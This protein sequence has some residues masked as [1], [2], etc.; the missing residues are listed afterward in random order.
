MSLILK[1]HVS[2]NVNMQDEIWNSECDI[3][4]ESISRLSSIY[5]YCFKGENE[6]KLKL[7]YNYLQWSM[8][9]YTVILKC[10][11]WANGVPVMTAHMYPLIEALII[12]V[13]SSKGFCQQGFISMGN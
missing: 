10:H 12:P 13:N 6:S 3:V 8:V 2:S 1:L 9:T 5:Y 4:T 11:N 7:T